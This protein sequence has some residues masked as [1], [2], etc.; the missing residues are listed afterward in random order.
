MLLLYRNL[1]LEVEPVLPWLMPYVSGL[2]LLGIVFFIFKLSESWYASIFNKPL[3]RHYFVYKKLSVSQEKTLKKEFAF[4][5]QLTVKQKNQFQHRVAHFITDKKFISRSDIEITERMK[6]LIA[7]IGCM[8]SFGRRNY[9]YGLIQFTLIYPSHF[10]SSINKNYHKGEF[11]PREKA[12]VLSWEDFEHGFKINNDNLNVGIHEFMHAM[13]LEAKN[14]TDID[15]VRFIKQYNN[16][17]KLIAKKEVREKLDS[18]QF[19][20]T[21]AFTNQ[22][23]FMAVLAEYF[24]ESPE[25]FKVTF[26]KLYEYTKKLLN[27]NFAGY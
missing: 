5:N 15:S 24:F 20:R 25:E 2:I 18:T 1:S 10:F 13:Q 9:N 3:F 6:V 27:F 26:P 11:N 19:F 22:Y 21:Y 12:L 8:L 23:E 16:I 14:S 4:Y 17:L 7:A